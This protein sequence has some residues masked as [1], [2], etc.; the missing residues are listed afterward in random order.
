MQTIQNIDELEVK[1]G[2]KLAACG[3]AVSVIM[4]GVA[5]PALS[6]IAVGVAVA[7]C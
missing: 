5:F 4:L 2:Q 3:F 6:M 1:G 7:A